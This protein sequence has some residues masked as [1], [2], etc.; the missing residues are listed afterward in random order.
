[1]EATC[2]AVS[3]RC[4][5]GRI[6]VRVASRE[7]K[8]ASA[9]PASASTP[10]AQR[11]VPSA[12]SISVSGRAAKTARPL[13]VVSKRTRTWVPSISRS[14]KNGSRSPRAT[15]SSSGSRWMLSGSGAV[16]RSMR[17]MRMNAGA[18]PVSSTRSSGTGTVWLA[19]ATTSSEADSDRV[20]AIR[21]CESSE[22]SI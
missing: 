13:P 18:S 12:R 9:I 5:T 1:M 3:V 15:A 2:S 8:T 22:A 7:R 21:T 4:V 17:R 10:S 16:V 6:A 14:A 11:S 19:P 20:P